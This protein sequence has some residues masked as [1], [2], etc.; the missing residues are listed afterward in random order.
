[1]DMKKAK[2][3]TQLTRQIER[4]EDFLQSLYNKDY[5]DEFSIYYRGAE[6]CE[7]EPEALYS[8]IDFYQKK[9][10]DA[11]QKLESI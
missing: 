8:L 11:K 4:S 5:E 2:E 9:Q 10:Q 7:L 6:T 1:M 3:I